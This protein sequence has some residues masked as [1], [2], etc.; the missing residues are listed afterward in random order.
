MKGTVKAQEPGQIEAR[1]RAQVTELRRLASRILEWLDQER[2]TQESP[3]ARQPL[4]V[5]LQRHFDGSRLELRLLKEGV[6]APVRDERDQSVYAQRCLCAEIGL[7]CALDAA[8]LD[9]SEARSALESSPFAGEDARAVMHQGR[10]AELLNFVISAAAHLDGLHE[11]DAATAAL[12]NRHAMGARS[13]NVPGI[14][15]W[16]E[17][18]AN[19]M[20]GLKAVTAVSR[21][22]ATELRFASS[23]KPDVRRKL[24]VA[25]LIGLA[26]SEFGRAVNDLLWRLHL[27]NVNWAALRDIAYGG[28]LEPPDDP[29]RSLEKRLDRIEKQRRS[30]EKKYTLGAR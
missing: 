22:M 26:T 18:V 27:G 28:V 16:N 24:G 23:L 12:Q 1:R 11:L 8:Q 29:A 9:P 15:G 5:L 6:S 10:Q 20:A 30:P 3:D 14:R 2:G 17:G 21:A 7:A 25:P 13:A 19:A 4:H